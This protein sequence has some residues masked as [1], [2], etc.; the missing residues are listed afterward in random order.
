MSKKAILIT[1]VSVS[2]VVFLVGLLSF[3][4]WQNQ[5]MADVAMPPVP[6]LPTGAPTDK[7]PVPTEPRLAGDSTDD[8]YV[9]VLDVN[10]LI[11]HWGETNSDYNLA[12]GQGQAANT[13]DSYDIAPVF[14]NWHCYEGRA[15]KSCPYKS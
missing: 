8:G 1:I 2:V 9:D 12:D 13:I 6:T 4:M 15:D 5:P 7:P 10:G 14:A 3:W 11:I